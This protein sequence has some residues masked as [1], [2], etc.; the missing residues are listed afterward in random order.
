ME[1]GTMTQHS[2]STESRIFN[3]AL[4]TVVKTER[5][6]QNIRQKD[7]AKLIG[8]RLNQMNQFES[9]RTA[10]PVFKLHKIGR[11]LAV[12]PTSFVERALALIAKT[13]EELK[14]D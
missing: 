13:R 3:T 14:D 1:A 10:I 7:L 5:K 4:A 8:V 11:I 12:D 9:G 6:E 2:Y